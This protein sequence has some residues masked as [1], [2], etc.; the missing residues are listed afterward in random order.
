M[1]SVPAA[2]IVANRSWRSG[3]LGWCSLMCMDAGMVFI[4][5]IWVFM[6]ER[7]AGVSLHCI[8]FKMLPIL[9]AVLLI[10]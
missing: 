9:V 8:V 10:A 5:S 4:A 7:V 3:R 2:T 1:R 6:N